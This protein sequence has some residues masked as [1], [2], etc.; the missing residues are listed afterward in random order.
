MI[1]VKII[2]W[3]LVLLMMAGGGYYAYENY[4]TSNDITPFNPENTQVVYMEGI[5]QTHYDV[6]VEEQG[7]LMLKVS[8]VEGFADAH[9]FWDTREETLVMTTLENVFRFQP[10]KDFYMENN[11]SD[12]LETPMIVLN[13]QPYLPVSVIEPML[14]IHWIFRED[15]QV[16]VL[17]EK[18]DCR[19]MAEV[20]VEGA[21]IREN[22]SIRA[23]L[24][25]A[26]LVP[27]DML[28][29]YET[30]EKWVK[31]RTENGLIGYVHKKEVKRY[32]ECRPIERP[33][34]DFTT[35]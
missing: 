1:K 20:I 34:P 23:P 12:D 3:L 21:S 14:N 30:H 15:D 32:E 9:F 4:W 28:L 13:N 25:D 5:P 2:P 27:G 10:K 11:R 7:E 18:R 33:A 24:Y 31:V 22:A 35:G 17:E 16:L 19:L 26:Q 29:V 6:Y 8:Y